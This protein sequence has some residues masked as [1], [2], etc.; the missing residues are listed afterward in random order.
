VRVAAGA[1][2]FDTLVESGVRGDAVEVEELEGS[3]SERDGNG[4]SEALIGALQKRLDTGVE[5]DLPAEGTE[6]ECR[7]EVAVLGR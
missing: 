7:D 2:E 5:S 6:D 3:E 1:R 4:I